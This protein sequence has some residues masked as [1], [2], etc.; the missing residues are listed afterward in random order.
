MGLAKEC[1]FSLSKNDCSAVALRRAFWLSRPVLQDQDGKL[2]QAQ[3]G[4]AMAK[5]RFSNSVHDSWPYRWPSSGSPCP[6]EL[7]ETLQP[8]DRGAIRNPLAE[9]CS[10]D[11]WF[12]I[13][14][15][16]MPR[17]LHLSLEYRLALH[18][19]GFYAFT[20][21]MAQELVPLRI[22]TRLTRTWK[23][24]SARNSVSESFVC[25]A[26]TRVLRPGQGFEEGPWR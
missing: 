16:G 22:G 8:G 25:D 4:Q 15:R 3:P 18:L 17:G 26:A 12:K 23:G 10:K 6:I 1:E 2:P 19:S 21:C 9:F 20:L 5:Q 24:K 13:P 11:T 7:I 14:W